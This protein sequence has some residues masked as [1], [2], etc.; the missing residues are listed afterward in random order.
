VR[1]RDGG[2]YWRH[3]GNWYRWDGR[4]WI[5]WGAPFG[6]FVS[7]LPWYYTTV[8]WDGVPYY[9]ANDTYYVWDH[10]QQQYEV[11]A[12]PDGVEASGASP[13]PPSNDL[14]IY[15]SSGQ[16]AEQQSKDRVEC[17]AWASGQ[18]GFNPAVAGGGVVAEK[19]IPLRY[20]HGEQSLVL[21]F[22][23]RIALAAA[24]L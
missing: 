8:W 20:L 10:A 21:F 15:P 13:L 4:R 3:G 19:R 1:G 16:S 6:L 14:F 24:F 5:V 9:Y 23:H 22:D 12:P 2:R 11:V 7:F 18:T 17:E